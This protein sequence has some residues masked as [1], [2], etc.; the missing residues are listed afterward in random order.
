MVKVNESYWIS[1]DNSISKVD[2]NTYNKCASIKAHVVSDLLTEVKVIS[3]GK[4]TYHTMQN[5]ESD[6]FLLDLIR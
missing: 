6:S 3:K 4:V 5:S 1:N 2:Y